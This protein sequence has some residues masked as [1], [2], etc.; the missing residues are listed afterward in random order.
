LI[1]IIPIF[2]DYTQFNIGS[3]EPFLDKIYP[4]IVHLYAISNIIDINILV[5]GRIKKPHYLQNFRC[6]DPKFNNKR[7]KFVLLN[8]TNFDNVSDKFD[9]VIKTIKQDQKEY[10]YIFTIPD[11]SDDSKNEIR[12]RIEL[13]KL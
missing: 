8:Q 9:I 11:F 2:K 3:Y 1:K 6:V 13:G 7:V 10:K 4:S 12:K 5:F